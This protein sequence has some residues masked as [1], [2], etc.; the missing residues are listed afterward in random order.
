M[1]ILHQGQA[2]VIYVFVV[3]MCTEWGVLLCNCTRNGTCEH[4]GVSEHQ[5]HIGSCSTWNAYS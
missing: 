1:I 3:H 5:T 4:G 2:V